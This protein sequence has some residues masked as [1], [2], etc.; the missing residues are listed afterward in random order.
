MKPTPYALLLLLALATVR[1]HAAAA[2]SP[3]SQAALEV[4]YESARNPLHT[5]LGLA[6][7][8]TLLNG[9][10]SW[11]LVGVLVSVGAVVAGFYAFYRWGSE[12]SASENDDF[13][14]MHY[15][16]RDISRYKKEVRKDCKELQYQKAIVKLS[17]TEDI[18]ETNAIQKLKNVVRAIGKHDM[19]VEKNKNKNASN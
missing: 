10:S 8:G 13:E 15:T 19:V 16:A 17:G 14:S 9:P 1:P 11:D 12:L 7:N 2:Q 5:Y 3:P 4:V 18:D 6:F